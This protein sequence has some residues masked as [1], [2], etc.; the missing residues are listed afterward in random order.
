MTIYTARC[1]SD[2]TEDWPFW[3][4]EKDG[5]NATKEALEVAG[6]RANLRGR[7]FLHRPVAEKIAQV[8]NAAT[9]GATS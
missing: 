5:I 3:M 1:A 8:A 6:Y 9:Q 2:R 4:I 7:V